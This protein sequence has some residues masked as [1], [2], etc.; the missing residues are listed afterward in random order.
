MT[1]KKDI[2]YSYGNFV[3]GYGIQG[4][5]A[6]YNS[7]S[8]SVNNSLMKFKNVLSDEERKII[9]DS[10]F[11]TINWFTELVNA[12]SVLISSNQADPK[13]NELNN[14][15]VKRL[16]AITELQQILANILPFMKHYR[17]P[18]AIFGKQNLTFLL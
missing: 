11:Y 17:P 2:I 15:L 3:E 7:A 4:S 18:I 10:L 6:I 1:I 5:G 8:T 9:C 16:N 12:F 13:Q 14:K